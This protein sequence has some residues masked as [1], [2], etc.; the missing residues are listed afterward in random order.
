L[1]SSKDGSEEQN[2]SKKFSHLFTVF[3]EFIFYSFKIWIFY[4]LAYTKWSEILIR[5][6]F[7]IAYSQQLPGI[8]WYTTALKIMAILTIF[9]VSWEV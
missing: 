8:E 9:F 7:N 4:W 1:G 6:T 3:L 2:T 5:N